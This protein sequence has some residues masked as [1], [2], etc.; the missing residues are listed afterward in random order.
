MQVINN[1]LTTDQE[2]EMS[3]AVANVVN[4]QNL[5]PEVLQGPAQ[6]FNQAVNENL[7][8]VLASPVASNVLR[9]ALLMY[10]GLAAPKLHPAV[11]R[12]FS[13]PAFRVAVLGL[14]LWTQNNDPALS[15]ALAML[16][17]VSMNTFA[18]RKPF[19]R[20]LSLPAWAGGRSRRPVPRQRSR[21]N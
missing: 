13:L 11:D 12:L 20:F 5:I 16:F 17:I 18:G 19:E 6:S 10:A 9:L 15:L 4:T 21:R 7:G 3:E 14:V 8:W 1:K 2:E